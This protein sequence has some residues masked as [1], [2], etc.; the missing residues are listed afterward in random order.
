ML[1]VY[2][3]RLSVTRQMVSTGVKMCMTLLGTDPRHFSGISMRRG[4]I[5][6]PI[7]AGVQ[8]PILFLQSGHGSDI[9]GRRYMQPTDPTLLYATGRAV[10]GST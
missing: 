6:A 3:L 4:G 1:R 5:S 9:L 7:N 2:N 8:E 10:L